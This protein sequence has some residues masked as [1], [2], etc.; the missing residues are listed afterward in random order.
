MKG[1]FGKE[2][3]KV[4]TGLPYLIFV[5]AL[6]T[7]FFTQFSTDFKRLEKPQPGQADYGTKYEEIPEILMPRAFDALLSEFSSNSYIAYPIGFYKNVRLND[8]RQLK[9]AEIIAELSGDPLEQIAKLTDVKEENIQEYLKSLNP[10]DSLDTVQGKGNSILSLS[11]VK[12]DKSIEYDRFKEL[13]DSADRCIGGGSSYSDLYLYRFGAV[14]KTYQDALGDYT[15]MVEKDKMTGAYARLFCDYIGIVLGLFPVFVAVAM[16]L[17]DKSARV[18]ELM[19]TRKA[20]SFSI[21]ITRYLAMVVA[22]MIPVILAA[23]YGTF[24][25]VRL[26]PGMSLDYLAFVKY[27]L[28]WLM[29]TLMTSAAVGTFVTELTSTPLAIVVQGIWWYLGMFSG[30]RHMDGGYG[31]DLMLRHNTIGNTQV[32]LSNIQVLM[33][34]RV[35]YVALSIFLVVSTCLIY[36]LK[37]KGRLNPFDKVTKMF[38]NS[39]GRAEA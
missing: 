31:W 12:L 36:E 15:A 8:T 17:K 21:V 39:R 22:M 2:F 27:S 14:P 32:Y 24:L 5:V 11:D 4:V 18:N 7:F 13:M 3:K 34:N 20:S 28:F 25:V 30:L 1:L 19:Y 37:R 9:M 29:P 38:R 10:D 26:Y 33:I 35:F 6:L 23:V 16:G